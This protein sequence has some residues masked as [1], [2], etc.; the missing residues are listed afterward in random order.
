VV[1]KFYKFYKKASI[2]KLEE[3]F[4]LIFHAQFKKI[5]FSLFFK[6]LFMKF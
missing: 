3:P 6:P 4:S 1:Q 5:C 2:M